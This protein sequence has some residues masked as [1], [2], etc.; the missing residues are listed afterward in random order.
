MPS[1]RAIAFLGTDCS[2]SL[3]GYIFPSLAANAI[4]AGWAWQTGYLAVAGF[5]ALLLFAS[6]FIAF[7]AVGRAARRL[8][9]G[10]LPVPRAGASTACVALFAFGL[11]SYLCGQGAFLIWA[12]HVLAT[13]FGLRQVDAAGIIGQFWGPSIFGLLAAASIVTRVAPR[14]VMIGA[15]A[16]ATVSLAVITGAHDAHGF[17]AATFAFG[18]SSTCL[19]KLMISIGSEQIPHAPP[20]LVT[21]LLLSASVGGTLAPA[22]SARIVAAHGAHAGIVM[23]A[24]CYALTLGCALG[25]LALER[26][27][28][29]PAALPQVAV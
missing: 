2:F 7:P 20:Q 25:A 3:A 18:F 10:A 28:R 15:A 27:A 14:I 4:A 9:P 29:R 19:F 16:L 1:A 24:C 23:A 21:F 5:A 13:A 12:P 8:E 11:A 26:M 22:V 6:A 17:F